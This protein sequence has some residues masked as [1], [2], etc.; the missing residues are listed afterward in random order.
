M[1]FNDYFLQGG[2]LQG[3]IDYEILQFYDVYEP[4]T[5]SLIDMYSL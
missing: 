3:V 4:V 1:N 5:Y 2:T